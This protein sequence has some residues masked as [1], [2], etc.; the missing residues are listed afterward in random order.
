[1]HT[2]SKESLY[3]PRTAVIGRIER[4]TDREKVFNI[5]LEDGA[6]LGHGPGQ[7]VEVSLFGIG[8]A[9]ISICS[10]PNGN[11][12]F[13]LCV[14]AAGNVTNALHALEAGA[15]VGIRGPFGHG[16]EPEEMAEKDILFV[17]GGIGLAPL[18]SLIHYVVDLERRSSFGKVTI[19]YG[20]RSPEEL[21]F[22]EDLAFWKQRK[23]VDLHVTVDSGDAG[24]TGH[25]G[26]ITT[27]FPQL[28]IDAPN[29]VAVIVGPPIMYR[30]V[31]LE[32]LQKD[33]PESQIIVSLERR[34]KCGL[35]KCGHCQIE[36][37]YVCQEGPVFS[38]PEI[39]RMKGAI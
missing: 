16:F 12:D 8:E 11:G 35:G 23:D 38:Y 9:P 32:A 34:M 30:F 31:L 25:V 19:L 36:G 3:V 15:K 24:W 4:L 6:P 37:V 13:Q 7:F 18:R 33:I 1:M 29:T 26:V 39:K 22:K 10:S 27:L 2:Q 14:R 20:A 28:E 17:A 5:E 21:L